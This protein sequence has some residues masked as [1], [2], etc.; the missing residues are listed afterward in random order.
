MIKVQEERIDERG[1][2]IIEGEDVMGDIGL[3]ED[4]VEGVVE[5]LR[6]V[7]AN[8]Q[9]LYIK[10]LHYHW[11]IVGPEFF[12]VHKLL[13]D[14]YNALKEAGD[15]V[16]ERIRG[17][18]SPVQ[19]RMADFLKNATIKETKTSGLIHASALAELVADHETIMREL[20]DAIDRCAEKWKDQ[21]AADL[22]TGLL[23]QHQDMA[24]ML[25]SSVR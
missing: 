10:T 3:E 17:Y 13:D 15:A 8:I 7:L 20:R 23:Q 12:S 6:Q 21:G 25:R 19:G 2:L 9:V 4:A 22:L 1:P 11:N 16:A 18:G 14:Q 5:S 24:W